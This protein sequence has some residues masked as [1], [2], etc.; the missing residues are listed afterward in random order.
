MTGQL[1]E[2]E[3]VGR[4]KFAFDGNYLKWREALNWVIRNQFIID[5]DPTEPNT[6]MLSDLQFT[7]AD[8]IGVDANQVRIYSALGSAFDFFHGVDLF[9]TY[10][11]RM[12]TIDLT[13]NESKRASGYKAD[14]I[15]SE[16]DFEK[17]NIWET[18]Q[19]ISLLLA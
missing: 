18:A 13:I 9:I 15:L 3:V 12:V 16:G 4:K 7:V 19:G 10:E 11:G 14:V 6:L 8:T 5:N 1:F 2:W 17:E